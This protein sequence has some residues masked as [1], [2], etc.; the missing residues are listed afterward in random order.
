MQRDGG[1]LGVLPVFLSSH[2][3]SLN[4]LQLPRMHFHFSLSLSFKDQNPFLTTFFHRT[5]VYLRSDLWVRMSVIIE[6]CFVDLTDVTLTDAATNSILTDDVD[7]G[8]NPRHFG[9]T[10]GASWWPILAT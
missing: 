1:G 3:L 4:V 6:T 8:G 5:Q 10:S 7:R 2:P 9:N